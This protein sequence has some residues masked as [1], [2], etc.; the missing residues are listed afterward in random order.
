MPEGLPPVRVV[1]LAQLKLAAVC[2]IHKKASIGT[3]RNEHSGFLCAAQAQFLHNTYQC[4]I[5]IQRSGSVDAVSTHA[6]V[7][8]LMHTNTHTKE[9][10]AVIARS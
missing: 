2:T 6:R 5:Q 9:R 4:T 8:I 7:Q 1:K 3:K 10:E